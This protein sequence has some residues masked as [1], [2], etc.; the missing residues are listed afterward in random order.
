MNWREKLE[1]K[2]IELIS[3]MRKDNS[4][5]EGMYKFLYKG[6]WSHTWIT[7]NN[8]RGYGILKNEN[9]IYGFPTYYESVDLFLENF[10]EL[11]TNI[12]KVHNVK[13]R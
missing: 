9:D 4:I 12:E 3:F 8:H 6:I 1:E 11:V 7:S 13:L 5:V 10:D 2:G